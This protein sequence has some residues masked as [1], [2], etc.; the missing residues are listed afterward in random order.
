VNVLGMAVAFMGIMMYL[1]DK[2]SVWNLLFYLAAAALFLSYT[3]LG[4]K[5]RA[6]K[7]MK[8]NDEFRFS[9]EYTFSDNG[10]DICQGENHI[11]YPWEG[12]DRVVT[13]PKTIGFYYGKEEALIV[14]KESFGTKFVSIMQITVTNISRTRTADR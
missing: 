3:P 14:P 6:K 2:A 11:A 12:I 9:K 4:L 1:T 5:H 8:I 13:T 10:I 7:Q